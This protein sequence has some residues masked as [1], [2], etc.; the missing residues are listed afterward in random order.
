MTLVVFCPVNFFRSDIAVM[1]VFAGINERLRVPKL[2]VTGVPGEDRAATNNDGDLEDV[3]DPRY[4][5][6]E[7]ALAYPPN[8]RFI[9]SYKYYL[10]HVACTW[11]VNENDPTVDLDKFA[12]APID[13][14]RVIL[15]T[16]ACIMIGDSVVLDKLRL[17]VT[18]INVK[19]MFVS[20]EDRENTHQ[21]TYSR[22]CDIS[23][24]GEYYR[25]LEFRQRYMSRFD[26]LAQKYKDGD[27]GVTLLFIMLCENV[28]FAPMFQILCYLATTGYAPHICNANR[29][30]MRDECIHYRHA[31]ELLSSFKRKPPFEFARAVLDEF[32]ELTLTLARDILDGYDDGVLN[33][34][35]VEAHFRHVV[36]SFMS[37]NSLF[38]DE[39]EESLAESRH[40][41]SPAADY[42]S[43]PETEV[44]INLM[45]SVSTVYSVPCVRKDINMDF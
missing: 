30:V 23:T 3:Q 11:T 16:A 34:A 5:R 6:D 32:C 7:Y 26:K 38:R 28:M 4:E 36:F 13:L 25:S 41:S 39:E 17:Y 12:K 10:E 15:R 9:V 22:W 18:P 45:E 42:M 37:E 44:K 2:R 19:M 14:Q 35:N 29:L 20:Q 8:P 31:R 27:I 43:L 24:D 21:I 33:Y 40:G 1:S